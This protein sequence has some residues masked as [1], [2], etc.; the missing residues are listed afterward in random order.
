MDEHENPDTETET[1]ELPEPWALL[2][3]EVVC[4]NDGCNLA[5]HRHLPEC[6]VCKEL[7]R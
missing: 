2:P 7:A 3:T 6:P 1:D 5:Y 4:R